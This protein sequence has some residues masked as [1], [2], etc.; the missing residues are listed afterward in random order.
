MQATHDQTPQTGKLAP[1]LVRRLLLCCRWGDPFRLLD[2][3]P[4]RS[5]PRG[6][7][8]GG[9]LRYQVPLRAI[10]PAT[11]AHNAPLSSAGTGPESHPPPQLPTQCCV[12]V[13]TA[14]QQAF[15]GGSSVW[16]WNRLWRTA[17]NW[18]GGDARVLM[19]VASKSASQPALRICTRLRQCPHTPAEAQGVL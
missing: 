7:G 16:D 17:G 9:G 1:A 2:S 14:A 11:T 5:V 18:E 4:S 13:A 8:G 15:W 6:C 19:R 3:I 12:H 10:A